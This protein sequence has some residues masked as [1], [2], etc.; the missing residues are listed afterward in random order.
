MRGSVVDEVR[1]PNDMMSML[2]SRSCQLR[3]GKYDLVRCLLQSEPSSEM[4]GIDRALSVL[5]LFKEGFDE[6]MS[7]IIHNSGI[8]LHCLGVQGEVGELTMLSP[9]MT[10]LL[11]LEKSKHKQ[12]RTRYFHRQKQ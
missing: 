7:L 4:R 8:S 12:R 9:T 10:E 1:M 3:F 6:H 2:L 11:Q 5:T